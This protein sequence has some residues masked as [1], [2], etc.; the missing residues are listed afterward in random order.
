MGLGEGDAGRARW[1]SRITATL[2][3][4]AKRIEPI[5]NSQ[6]ACRVRSSEK[7]QTLPITNATA[8]ANSTRV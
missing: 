2:G 5:R 3:R 6:S 4:T 8:A 1:T 7:K